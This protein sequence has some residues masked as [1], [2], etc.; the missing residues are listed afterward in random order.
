M[1]YKEGREYALPWV[2]RSNYWICI[3]PDD[4]VHAL[5]KLSRGKAI[6]VDKLADNQ[7]REALMEDVQLRYKIASYF[8]SWIN[9]TT[10]LP[11]YMKLARTVML[12]KTDSQYPPVGEVRV[13]AILPALTKLYELFLLREL[14]Q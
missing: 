14:R 10:K 12:S 9:G 4:I 6:G 1:Y 7:L 8:E 2:P 13:I 11:D 3:T 5:S